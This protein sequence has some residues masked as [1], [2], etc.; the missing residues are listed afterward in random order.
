MSYVVISNSL[1]EDFP[2]VVESMQKKFIHMHELKG[3]STDSRKFYI[4]GD[5]LLEDDEQVYITF[6]VMSNGVKVINVD[7]I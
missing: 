1:I 7:K 3:Y 6:G 4:T 2:G 5:D